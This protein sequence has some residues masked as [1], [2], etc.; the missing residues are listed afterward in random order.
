MH[1]LIII[2]SDRQHKSSHKHSWQ[3][4]ADQC[5]LFTSWDLCIL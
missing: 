2:H 5:Q 1:S 4:N 3:N